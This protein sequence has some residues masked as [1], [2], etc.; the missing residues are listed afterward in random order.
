MKINYLYILIFLIAL[1]P[2][3]E[4]FSYSGNV[5]IIET[6]SAVKIDGRL[7]LNSNGV[8][9]LS[10]D[11]E[12]IYDQEHLNE[13]YERY[14]IHENERINLNTGISDSYQ[15]FRKESLS[16]DISKRYVDYYLEKNNYGFIHVIIFCYTQKLEQEFQLEMIDLIRSNKIPAN[17][18][19]ADNQSI[20]NLAGN[21][22][23][24]THGFDWLGINHIG[25][26]SN[27][28]MSWSLHTSYE[29][30][31]ANSKENQSLIVDKN[32]IKTE[33]ID[34]VYFGKVVKAIRTTLDI[35]KLENFEVGK[36][37]VTYYLVDEVNGVYISSS[38]S[39]WNTIKGS[40]DEIPAFFDQVIR[41]NV[42]EVYSSNLE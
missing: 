23:A 12:L 41:L 28:Q 31:L 30:A 5:S 42:P 16:T 22:I 21:E 38:I 3:R 15:F 11:S 4:G 35:S 13:I 37:L 9:V 39:F 34:V 8:E 14:S 33:E 10:Y 29:R 1:A 20:F 19:K 26:A 27:G 7:Y 24:L 6:I 40:T 2:L 18:F 17:C 36:E 32:A 25:S